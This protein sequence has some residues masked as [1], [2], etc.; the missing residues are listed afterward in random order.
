MI[1]REEQLQSGFAE[2]ASLRKRLEPYAMELARP[3]S[4]GD[5]RAKVVR[6]L[7]DTMTI[8]AHMSF[9]RAFYELS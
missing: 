4:T 2:I 3:R 9:H 6:A 5:G 1:G 7:D 8:G